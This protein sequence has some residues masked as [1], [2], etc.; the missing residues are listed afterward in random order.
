MY[1]RA[2]LRSTFRLAVN[3]SSCSG[4]LRHRRLGGRR[5]SRRHVT[6]EDEDVRQITRNYQVEQ[7][8][9]GGKAL[10]PLAFCR[11]YGQEHLITWRRSAPK[12]TCYQ[13]RCGAVIAEDADGP[14]SVTDSYL[15]ISSGLMF[16]LTGRLELV[17]TTSNGSVLACRRPGSTGPSAVTSSRCPL[18]PRRRARAGYRVRLGRLAGGHH[19]P[20]PP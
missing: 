1:F 16:E 2:I 19:P 3:A 10:L 7:A 4:R 9:S 18:S 12:T 5:P 11:E 6:F 14:L 13:A 20:P 17:A 15:Y 8:G